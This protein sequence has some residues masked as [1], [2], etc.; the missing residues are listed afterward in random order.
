M[1]LTLITG[2]ARS[3]KSSFA[4]KIIKEKNKKT[5][6]IATAT[7]FDDEMTDRIKKHRSSRPSFWD[8]YEWHLDIHSKIEDIKDK[9][10]IVLLDCITIYINNIMYYKAT[11]VD[12]CENIDEIEQIVI[13]DI[14][15]MIDEFKKTNLEI[16]LVTN[17]L[18]SGIVPMSKFARYF[19]DIAGRVN[20]YL[21]SQSDNV[22]LTVSG[23]DIKIK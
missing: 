14:K 17:E 9:Y 23:I 2:G 20:Q 5:A 18:G 8:T 13:N 7:N 15:K 21:A 16:Y 11:S 1:N 22:Y 4:E 19:R 10:E 12:E 6:Y 3:G